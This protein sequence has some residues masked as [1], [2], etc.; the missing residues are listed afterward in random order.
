MPRRYRGGAGFLLIICLIIS[1]ASLALMWYAF[2][3]IAQ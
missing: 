1:G 3:R 2:S